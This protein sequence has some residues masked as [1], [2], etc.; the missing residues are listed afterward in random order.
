M[1][2]DKE[3]PKTPEKCRTF[4]GFPEGSTCPVCGTNDDEE[5]RLIPIMGTEDGSLCEAQP[6]HSSCLA[7]L[8]GL[9]WI[10][11]EGILYT[12]EAACSG[13]KE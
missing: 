9:A 4:A 6:F 2:D 10:R 11:E 8:P 5:C 12:R 1:T 7:E 13:P 3:S